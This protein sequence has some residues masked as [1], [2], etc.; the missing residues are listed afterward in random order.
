MSISNGK[1]SSDIENAEWNSTGM[2]THT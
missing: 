1:T 2:L